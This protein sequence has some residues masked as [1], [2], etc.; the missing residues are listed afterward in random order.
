MMHWQHLKNNGCPNCGMEFNDLLYLYDE[1]SCPLCGWKIKE[2]QLLGWI[3]GKASC[4]ICGEEE[5]FICPYICDLE[6]LECKT[7]GY[8]TMEINDD[9]RMY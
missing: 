6:N 1:V 3:C 9:T 8:M 5:I 7:C 2:S 4:R